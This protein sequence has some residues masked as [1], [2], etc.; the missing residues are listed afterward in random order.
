MRKWFTG[1]AVLALVLSMAS[2]VW[3]GPGPDDQGVRILLTSTDAKAQG[4]AVRHTFGDKVTA[5]VPTAA[6]DGLRKAGLSFEVVPEAYAIGVK[7]QGKPGGGGGGRAVPTTQVPYG[8]KMIYGNATLT[9]T[10]VSGGAGVTVAILDTGTTVTHPDFVR[11]DGSNLIV[12]C[13]NFSDTRISQIEGQCADGD[14]HGTHVTGTV[15]AAGG[16]DGLGIFGVAPQANIYA[17]KVLNDRGSGYADDIANAIRVAADRGA[18]IIS[19]SLGGSSGSSLY[20]D[21]IRYANSKGVL[22][23]AAA[24]NSGPNANTIGYPGGY[25]EVVAVAS[26]NPNEVVSYYSSRGLTDG[27]NNSIV[28]REVEVAGPGRSTISTYKDG[29]YYTMS[30]TSMATPHISGLAAKMWQGSATA[31]RS[32]L[33]SHA[34]SHDITTAEQINNAGVGYDIAAGYGL[35]QVTNLKQSTWNN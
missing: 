30:G 31:T 2:G 29:A 27:N 28:D 16:A 35:P 9:K 34:Q 23:I 10:G 12:D 20:L 18:D 33:V 1:L 17:Y 13:V 19:M 21:A 11:A 14:G 7:E 22:V 26:L 6:L 4:L 24:G 5:H 15:A 8:I 3:A 32:W 25:A